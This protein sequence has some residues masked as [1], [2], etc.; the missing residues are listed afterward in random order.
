MRFL[1]LYFF[2]IVVTCHAAAQNSNSFVNVTG[3]TG[4]PGMAN[5]FLFSQKGFFYTGTDQGL[6]LFDGLRFRQLSKKTD[7]V[8]PITALAENK[9]GELWVG[10]NNGT[11]CQFINNKYTAWSPQ[12]GLPQ[13]TISSIAFDKGGNMWIASKGEGLYVYHQNKLYNLNTDDGLGDNYVYDLHIAD[14]QII[15]A[16][17]RG[18]SLCRFDEK[19]KSIKT[20]TASN[21]LADNIVQTISPVPG[22]KQLIWLGFQNGC[23]GLFNIATLQYQNSY[24]G[25]APVSSLLQLAGELWIANDHEIAVIH[26][27]TFEVKTTHQISAVS[28]LVTDEE[29]NVWLLNNDALYKSA[30]EQLQSVLTLAPNESEAIN[31]ILIDTKGNSWITTREG[32]AVYETAGLKLKKQLIRLPLQEGSDVTALCTDANEN[33][34]VGTMGDGLFV[35]NPVDYT[36]LHINTVPELRNASI[37]SI[38][39]TATHIWVASLQGV[40]CG[41]VTN[42][43]FEKLNTTSETGS[44]YIYYVLEDSRGRIWFATDGKGISVWQ[45]GAFQ[46]FREKEGLHAKVVY[47]LAEDK[48][49]NIWCN[50]LNNGI[51]KY[52]GK[53]FKHFG[54]AEGLPDLNISSISTDAQGRLFCI[55]SKECFV[56]DAAT[57]IVIPLGGMLQ[58]EPLNTNLNSNYSNAHSVWFH[59]GHHIYKWM[60]PAYKTVLQSQTKILSVS[61]FLDEVDMSQRS[62]SYAENNFSFNFAGFYYSNPAAVAYRYKLEGYNNE[63]QFTKDGY[64]NFPKLAPGTYTFR[65]RSSVT[66]NFENANEASYSFTVAKPFWKRWWFILLSIAAITGLLISII[67]TRE[68]EVQKMQQLQ[69][70]KLKA[71]YET[72]K[73]QVNPHFLFNSFNTLLNIIEENP[74]KASDYVEHLS[75]F[76]RSIVNLREKDLIPLGEELR[77]IE[78]YFFIQ[79]KRF[80]TAL[81]FENL[82]TETQKNS[83]SIPPLSLQLLAEN[84]LKHNVVSKEQ[85]LTFH[86]ALQ[87]DML[88]VKNNLHLK[89]NHEKG[90]GLGLLNIKNRFQLIAGKEVTVRQTDNE[91]IVTL[92]LIKAV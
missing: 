84:A 8:S 60:L 91:F 72:L 22:Q 5:C 57:E 67:R 7:T 13:K 71:Q 54:L 39:A 45:N 79:K 33:I 6:F 56:I 44:A 23:A 55:A 92:P 28:S 15:A 85:P 51:Y 83:F 48:M 18:I 66:G 24:C 78:H 47:S 9:K 52:D 75:D 80:G 64:V 4:I 1:H 58:N 43:E 12:E 73:S 31:D 10:C 49:G 68:S 32:V 27:K 82:V 81:R 20:I 35:V 74:A 63:W 76:Y 3:D 37:L 11:V 30:G 16:T 90:E 87:S 29:A 70:E 2:L 65:V 50:T 61:L 59:A 17:D 34:W 53:K 21:G 86:I 36:S 38:S 46:S 88:V 40:W 41:A 69:T 14:D 77:I 42:Y 25:A 62:F 19:T 26:T 89:T